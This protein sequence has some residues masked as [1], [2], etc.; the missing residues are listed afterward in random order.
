MV[1]VNA[2]LSCFEKA[3]RWQQALGMVRG[4]V[5]PGGAWKS[6]R[7]NRGKFK[8]NWGKIKVK[9]PEDVSNVIHIILDSKFADLRLATGKLFL[10]WNGQDDTVVF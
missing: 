1:T 4:M 7:E 10:R 2:L 3:K 5:R 8:E 9:N 6:K